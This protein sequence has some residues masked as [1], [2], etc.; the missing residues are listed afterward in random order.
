MVTGTLCQL[1]IPDFYMEAAVNWA[2]DENKNVD[3]A[4]LLD[5]WYFG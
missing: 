2:V 5:R 1:I 3:V 4:S